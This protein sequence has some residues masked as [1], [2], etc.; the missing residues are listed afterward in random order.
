M[1]ISLIAAVARNRV[2]GR[3]DDLP[4]RLPEDL[5]RFKQRTLGHHLVL[6]RVTWE[7]VGA[8]PGR[9]TIVLSH[10]PVDL[11]DGVRRAA[12]LEEALEI[13]RAAG[14]DEVF[15]GGGGMVYRSALPLADRLY[16]T[17]VHAEVEGDVT[18]PSLDSEEWLEVEREDFAADERHAHSFSICVLDRVR[19]AAGER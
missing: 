17:R 3:R 7:A 14:E 13:A 19:A 15:I 6:G 5:R 4:W 8:L 16:L 12:N 1:R 10:T 9:K 18:F 11:P 2:I